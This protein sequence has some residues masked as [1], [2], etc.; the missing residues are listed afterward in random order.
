MIGEVFLQLPTKPWRV[1]A[2]QGFFSNS[3]FSATITPEDFANCVSIDTHGFQV[4]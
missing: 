4:T 3:R 1:I 2:P